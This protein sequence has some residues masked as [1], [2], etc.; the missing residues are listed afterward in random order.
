[1]SNQKPSVPIQDVLTFL[2]PGYVDY[3]LLFLH[4]RF[5]SIQGSISLILKKE[6]LP[7]IGQLVLRG[8]LVTDENAQE[9]IEGSLGEAESNSSWQL[10]EFQKN[11]KSTK[12]NQSCMIN[13]KVS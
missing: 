4:K 5:R 7:P 10:K 3:C 12:K 1:M 6:E 2:T 13:K 8:T 9:K 11:S